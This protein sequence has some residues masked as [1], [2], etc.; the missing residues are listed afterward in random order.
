VIEA[1]GQHDDGLDTD[2]QLARGTAYAAAAE[3]AHDAGRGLWGNC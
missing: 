1:L 2:Q 3:A